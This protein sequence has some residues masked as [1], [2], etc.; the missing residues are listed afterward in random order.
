MAGRE[1]SFAAFDEEGLLAKE[2]A[3]EGGQGGVVHGLEKAPARRAPGE[4][5]ILITLSHPFHDLTPRMDPRAALDPHSHIA[6]V[7]M[8]CDLPL[9][10]SPEAFWRLLAEGRCAVADFDDASMRAAGAREADL[11]APEYVRA[12]V[13]LPA[14]D[15]FDAAFFGLSPREAAVM[16]PQHRRFLQCAWAALEHAGHRPDDLDRQTGVFAG[17]GMGWY[18]IRNVIGHRALVEDLGEFLVRHLSNDKDFLSTRVS[19]QL[20]LRGPSLNVQTACSTSLVAVHLACQS[21]I[22]GECDMA[23]AGGVTHEIPQGQGYRYRE[24]EVRSADGRCRAFD[25][26]AGG[27][28]FGSGAG[29]VVLRRLG[30]A[31]RDGDTIYAVIRGTAINNDGAGKAGYLAP[32]VDG[33]AEA[34]AQALAVAGVPADTLGYVEAHGTGTRLGD[35]IEIAAL[36]Q[37]FHGATPGGCAIGSV[38]TNIGH[39]DTAAGVAGL[40]KTALSLQH[41]EVPA[42][43]FFE[44]PNPE[45]DFARSPFAV[46][47]SHR[48]WPKPGTRRAAVNSLGVGGTNAFAVLE[49]APHAGE[50]PV[51]AADTAQAQPIVLPLS[52]KTPEALRGR[53]AALAATLAASALPLV[54]I[55][56]TLR[57]GRM[58][59]PVRASVATRTRAEAVVALDELSRVPDAALAVAA[60]GTA[61]PVFAFPG[62]GAQRVG[63]ARGIARTDAAVRA[64]LEACVAELRAIGADEVVALLLEAAP[65]AETNARLRRTEI[66]QPALFAVEYALAQG[67]IARGLQPAAMLGHSLGEYVAATLAGVFTLPAALRLMVARGA[68]CAGAPAGAML[69]VALDDTQLRAL[70]PATL[71]V[72]AHNAPGQ[73]VVAGAEADIAAFERILG[74]RGLGARRLD[75][76]AAF[77]SRL[78][79][80]VL[81]A[82]RAAVVAAAPARVDGLR[83]VSTCTGDWLDAAQAASPDY[84]VRHLREP[85]RFTDAL[86][87]VERLRH[88]VLVEV[89][90]GRTLSKFAAMRRADARTVAVLPTGDEDA[91]AWANLP[92][93]LWAT[94]LPVEW[95]RWGQPMSGRRVPLPTYPF[96]PVT[97][98]IDPPKALAAVDEPSVALPPEGWLQTP[99]WQPA[100]LPRETSGALPPS[101]LVLCDAFGIGEALA[102]ALAAEG[103]AVRRAY[104][105]AAFTQEAAKFTLDPG[106]LAHWQAFAATPAP[107][108]LVDLWALDAPEDAIDEACRVVFDDAL[109]MAQGLA[110]W[111]DG[112]GLIW[113]SVGV[114]AH[115]LGDARDLRPTQ[116]LRAG[117]VRTWPQEA[118]ALRTAWFDLDAAALAAPARAVEALRAELRAGCPAET[119]ALRGRQRWVP[120]AQALGLAPDDADASTAFRGHVLLT[121]AFGG[122]GRD[123][124]ERLA[125][126]GGLECLWLVSRTPVEAASSRGAWVEALRALGLDARVLVADLA[127]PG[128]LADAAKAAGT[129]RIDTVLH[130]AGVLDDALIAMKTLP[131]AHAVLAPKLQGAREV[132]A[133]AESLGASQVLY[134]SSISAQMGAS[135]Q[136]DYTSANAFLD[137]FAA[138]ADATSVGT[139]HTAL[140]FSIWRDAGMAARLA[141][142]RGLAPPPFGEGLP[143]AHPLL[144][145]RRDEGTAT[146]FGGVV[147]PHSDWVLDGHRLASGDALLPGTGLLDLVA[148]GLQA[149][150]GRFTP[151]ACDG[152]TIAAP[153]VFAGDDSRQ[154][155]LRFTPLDAAGRA[156]TSASAKRF[157]VGLASQGPGDAEATEHATLQLEVRDDG[158][159]PTPPLELRQSRAAQPPVYV[160]PALRFGLEWDCLLGFEVGQ[161]EAELQLEATRGLDGPHPLHPALL[162]MALGAAQSAL[163]P[164][165]VDAARLLPFRYGRIEVLAPLPARV[166]S[167]QRARAEDDS[168]VLDIDVVDAAGQP[169]VR[170]RDFVLKPA[171]RLASAPRARRGGT[172]GG[173]LL[174]V[175][176]RDGFGSDEAFAA[177]ATVLSHPLPAQVALARRSVDTLVADTR[178]A[179]QAGDSVA[180]TGTT[181]ATPVLR[182]PGGTPFV[183]ATTPLQA[184]MVA[185][186]ERLLDLSGIGIEDDFFALGGHSLLLTRALSRLKREEGVALPI[187]A[188]FDAP[189]IR[190]WSALADAAGTMASAGAAPLP[191]LQPAPRVA[192]R[193]GRFRFPTTHSQRQLFYVQATAP[194]NTAYNIPFAFTLRGALDAAALAGAIHDVV[195]AHEALRTH[196]EV[197]DGEV[198]QVVDP[199][200]VPMHESVDLSAMPETERAA[201]L[202]EVREL[203]ARHVFDLS[204]GPPCLF[205]TVKLAADEHVLLFCLHHVLVDHLAVLH[206]GRMLEARYALRRR[207]AAPAVA[208]PALQ[209]PDFAVWQAAALDAPAIAQ[210]LPH[211]MDSLAACPPVLH[212]P[213]DRPRP[214]RQDFAGAEHRLALS[215]GTSARLRVF[216]QAT[217]Q[218][219]FVVVL[220]ALA[221]LMRAAS[222][223]ERLVIGCPFANRNA[224]E[225]EPVVG[226]FMNLL[227]LGLHLPD[228]Q[229]FDELLAQ[230]RR[231]V[232]RTQAVQDTPFPAILQAL[233]VPR[234]P[235]RNPLVQVWYTFQEAPMALQ[236]EGLEVTSEALPNGGAKL[237]LSFWFWDDGERVRGLVEYATAIYDEAIV[238]ALVRGLEATLDAGMAEAG[239]P[240][241]AAV[242]DPASTPAPLDSRPLDAMPTVVE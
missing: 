88:A 189:R 84:W 98:W 47:A 181:G 147:S 109:R 54:D 44:S 11:A 160:H 150:R 3:A 16:D 130:A 100:P 19:Y 66:A 15:Q 210:R 231:Q 75:T 38:K 117:P 134:F 215:A 185:L 69:A 206:I 142:E 167:R 25:A 68:L 235:S 204:A 43:L 92:G 18:L 120:H 34:A 119:V 64:A 71:D 59:M 48:P 89:G 159:D 14:H 193:D 26:N 222:G 146:V 52:A 161:G 239:G 145:H 105:G 232:T 163:A 236:F 21:L 78:L 46:A 6:I 79:D 180:D 153:L 170:V 12:G 196:F 36:S 225:L 169:C 61:L 138:R 135:G 70:L 62:Q 29:I 31:L 118:P 140:A 50:P 203:V 85:V 72:A 183:A 102:E 197:V 157:D 37:A 216:A 107:A 224:E 111:A 220:A 218:T 35:P 77:H 129:E 93:L 230:V 190:D 154:I 155:A 207:G 90:P 101:A 217:Q 121:G 125:R 241:P 131:A 158:A 184:R 133:L 80:G 104:R 227:P 51:D 128:E 41:G 226:L 242:H 182:R 208:G 202:A 178:R 91:G 165:G 87:T 137:A 214:A 113:L 5:G 76:S 94:G 164:P 99:V 122:A 60:D 143:Q 103:V 127:R 187:D 49:Q 45:I 55:A 97:H 65:S 173:A 229:R 114:H 151:F 123:I 57:E 152:L 81:E 33:Q 28:V 199:T 194:E 132:A 213:T 56:W 136:V 205:L 209:L 139:R 126:R 82:F 8:A 67:L 237:D 20:D 27:T 124:A 112:P 223:Q 168:L 200:A 42:S 144:R 211:W 106:E 115:P 179:A 234:D 177:I 108:V 95:G 39:L 24:E 53:A 10:D 221:R 233:G 74:E 228:G 238:E 2:D 172:P 58:A 83:V 156:T 32:S 110:P 191:P 73:T 149:L 166:T 96:A 219:P 212:L 116:A 188:A 9:A 13:R 148:W 1:Q 7:G 141:A 17:A 40:I 186:W 174:E 162:D 240:A 23:L 175:G 63:M 192:G 198:W 86:A 22:A 195:G 171:R 201:A 176:F 4:C 30:D